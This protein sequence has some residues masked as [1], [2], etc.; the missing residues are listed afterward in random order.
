MD[1]IKN[2]LFLIP[3]MLY[4][5]AESMVVAI[6]VTLV[7]RAFLTDFTGIYIKYFQW[8]AIIWILKVIF[9]DVFKMMAGFMVAP[10]PQNQEDK[11]N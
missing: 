6:F 2:L 5:F 11:E 4:Y 9:F 10:P 1:N 7:W 3:I 8:V